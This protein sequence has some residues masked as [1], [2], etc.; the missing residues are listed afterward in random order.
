[1]EVLGAAAAHS[2]LLALAEEPDKSRRRRLLELV[3]SFGPAIAGPARERLT[4]SRWY[5][6]RNMIVILQRVGDHAAMPEI[7]M[8]ANHPDLRVR[9]EA[10][11]WM[12][13]YDTG[14]P[15][16]LLNKAINDPDPKVAEAAVSL[17]GSY[18][19]KEALEPL[20]AIVAGLDLLRKRESIRLKALKALGELGD[21][22]ALVHLERFFTREWLPLVSK[23]ERRAAYRSLQSYPVEA[24]AGL[25]ARGMESRDAE[26]RRICMDLGRRPAPRAR[27][28]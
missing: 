3:V 22:A 6:V 4:D 9:L 28:S 25:V 27:A 12:L 10:I 16:E 2:F 11:K 19:I 23:A 1:M 17:A 7:R 5:V 14:M 8:C 26:I 20:V 18:G 21:P 24:R 13:A 15:R